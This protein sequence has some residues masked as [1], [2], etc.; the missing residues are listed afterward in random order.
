M[1]SWTRDIPLDSPA[2]GQGSL[3]VRLA[4]V[5]G[6]LE[7]RDLVARW[8]YFHDAGFLAEKV[9][10][11]HPDCVIHHHSGDLIGRKDIAAFFAVGPPND[12]IS[13]MRHRVT[14]QTV[15]FLSPTRARSFAQYLWA[16][17]VQGPDGPRAAVG[18]GWYSDVVVL[19]GEGWCF[20]ERTF[21]R[22]FDLALPSVPGFSGLQ[23]GREAV[24]NADLER[25]RRDGVLRT[26]KG[27]VDD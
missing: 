20:L 9:A 8:V 18:G 4:R 10:L 13:D 1:A 2:Y 5:E 7:V 12:A 17:T 25:L 24:D 19:D 11:H 22:T 14:S 3:E 16:Q 6:E 21:H 27:C 26:A 15:R 23:L